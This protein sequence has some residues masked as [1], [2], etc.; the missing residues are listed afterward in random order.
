MSFDI[1]M[2]PR[3][4]RTDILRELRRNSTLPVLM[5]TAREEAVVDIA[6]RRPGLPESEIRRIFEPFHW[7]A[8]ARERHSGGEGVGLAIT[9]RVAKIQGGRIEAHN[10]ED[11]GAADQIDAAAQSLSIT[12]LRRVIFGSSWPDQDLSWTKHGRTDERPACPRHGSRDCSVWVC[13]PA[14]SLWAESQKA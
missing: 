10:R 2:L 1:V 12:A 13:L 14:E 11:A 6:N 9:A 4:S 8:E 3:L 5:L 7:V